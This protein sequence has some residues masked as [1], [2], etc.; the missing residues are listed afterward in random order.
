MRTIPLA[1]TVRGV[2]DTLPE[3][4]SESSNTGSQS[5]IDPSG[6]S[7]APLNCPAAS[8]DQPL[9][10]QEQLVISPGKIHYLHVWL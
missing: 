2:Q 5:A 3:P 4:P 10:S 1:T 7:H 6:S 8:E 9:T